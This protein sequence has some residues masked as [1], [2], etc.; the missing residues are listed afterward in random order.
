[1]NLAFVNASG[2]PA[3]D[4]RVQRSIRQHAMRDVGRWRRK[5]SRVRNEH[6]SSSAMKTPTLLG[7]SSAF[8]TDEKPMMSLMRF[9]PKPM[10]IAASGTVNS[11][12]LASYTNG[13]DSSFPPNPFS[14]SPSSGIS[15]LD[16]EL[17]NSDQST[18]NLLQLDY[19]HLR[20]QGCSDLL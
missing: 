6:S 14:S 18:L 2:T 16:S 10:V 9:L 11:I 12:E 17:S 8:V 3:K 7:R 4:S 19:N 15:M 13:R 5:A 20:R 1:V